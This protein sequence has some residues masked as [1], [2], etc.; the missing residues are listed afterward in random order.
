MSDREQRRAEGLCPVCGEGRCLASSYSPRSEVWWAERDACQRRA[1]ARHALRYRKG[2]QEADI[3]A[4]A[5]EEEYA[6]VE[7]ERDEL[8]AQLAEAQKRIRELEA[9]PVGSTRWRK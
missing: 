3:W 6:R 9:T 8:S 2:K 7:A 4:A 5:C 1:F